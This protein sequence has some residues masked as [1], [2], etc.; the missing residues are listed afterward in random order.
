MIGAYW[1]VILV[2]WI[3]Q[4]ILLNTSNVETKKA[5][6]YGIGKN[7]ALINICMSFW[8]L[9]WTM[10]YFL[11]AEIALLL[12][13]FFGLLTLVNLSQYPA[14]NMKEFV[15]IHTPMKMLFVIVFTCDI[16]QNGLMGIG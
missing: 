4:C 16:W 11:L 15:F 2:L 12:A 9:F 5:L 3:G 6:A 14:R 10:K 7:L 1:M 8:T 13:G